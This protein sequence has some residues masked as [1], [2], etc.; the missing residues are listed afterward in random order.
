MEQMGILVEGS[1]GGRPG[2]QE[3]GAATVESEARQQRCVVLRG[4]HAKKTERPIPRTEKGTDT[5]RRTL[6]STLSLRAAES[7]SKV[8]RRRVGSSSQSEGGS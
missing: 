8:I 1:A 6:A 3:G 5:H 7:K 4:C 2:T